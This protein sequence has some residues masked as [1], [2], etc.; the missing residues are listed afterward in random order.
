[1][2]I[3]K[4]P[5]K[6]LASPLKSGPEH[7][8]ATMLLAIDHIAMQLDKNNINWLMCHLQLWYEPP[9]D[10]TNKRTVHPAKTRISL[11]IHPVWSESSLCTQWIAKDPSFLQWR[12]ISPGGCPGWSESSLGAH[13]ILLVLSCSG[14]YVAMQAW[15]QKLTLPG[16]LIIWAP[17]WE[18]LSS[19]FPTRWDANWPAQLQKLAGLKILGIIIRGIILSRQRITKMLIRLMR[20]LICMFVVR[21][22]H[23]QVFLWRGSYEVY[24]PGSEQQR[25][26]SDCA[27]AQADL[28]LCCSHME[29]QVS[30]WRG[31]F[32]P[33]HIT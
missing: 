11:G 1:M 5:L 15:N 12:L 6:I 29:K 18:N 30:S 16:D 32:F 20:R 19:G 10:K 24:Y 33:V 3:C 28:R 14:S 25:R 23:K 31:S 26:W 27:D 22:W 8:P 13:I 2:T 4:T 17:S 9:H 21:I 7:P